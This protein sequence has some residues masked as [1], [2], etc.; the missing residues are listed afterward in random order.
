MSEI[1]TISIAQIAFGNRRRDDYGDIAGLA[2]SIAKYDLIHP[3]T[4]SSMGDGG[5]KLVCGGR[6]IKAYQHLGRQQIEVRDRGPLSDAEI[7]AIAD[8]E[9]DDRKALTDYERSKL[10]VQ[11]AEDTAPLLSSRTEDKRPRGH[12]RKYAVPKED[13][14]QAIGTS[15]G[16]LVAAEQHVETAEAYPFMRDPSW[17]QSQVLEARQ[18]LQQMPHEQRAV[19]VAMISEPG[20]PAHKALPMLSN[21]RHMPEE[22]RGKLLG[23]YQGGNPRERD[24][25]VSQAIELPTAPDPRLLKL[26]AALREIRECVERSPVD[27]LTP[28][29]TELMQLMDVLIEDTRTLHRRVVAQL[30]EEINQ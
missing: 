5:Y 21:L 3:V 8:S 28:R 4:V 13:V 12:R 18:H 10:M 26:K 19:A 15:V 20:V 17:K 16:S 30:V 2:A 27:E 1:Q 11:K 9:D 29:Y 14:A 24:F 25:A 6:R 23:R 22:K 7:Q